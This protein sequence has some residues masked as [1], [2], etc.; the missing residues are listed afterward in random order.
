MT[1]TEAVNTVA[2][3]SGRVRVVC[4]FCGRMSAPLDSARFSD[5]PAGWSCAP[6]PD[7]FA[8]VDGSTGTLFKCSPCSDRRDFPITPREYLRKVTTL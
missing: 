3:K 2:L 5:L 1:A 6:Y 8:H 7:G 4:E